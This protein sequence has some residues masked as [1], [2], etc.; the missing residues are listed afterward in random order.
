MQ[1]I[2]CELTGERRLEV[3]LLQHRPEHLVL[4]YPAPVRER[5]PTGEQTSVRVLL[6]PSRLFG[7]FA[8]GR[9]L[10]FTTHEKMIGLP[11]HAVT[12]SAKGIT[13]KALFIGKK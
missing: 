7:R 3:P 10:F 6:P 5:H 12:V 4:H 9:M 8:I 13:S 11:V 1:W 2:L